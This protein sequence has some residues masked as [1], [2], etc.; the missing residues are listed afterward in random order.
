MKRCFLVFTDVDES[1]TSCAEFEFAC[2]A[3]SD[4]VELNGP[5]TKVS[6]S[7]KGGTPGSA[8]EG[9]DNTC[10]LAWDTGEGSDD[11]DGKRC[12]KFGYENGFSEGKYGDG[13]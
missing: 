3:D 2:A 9:V 12:C 4:A 5:G 8:N 10:V 1:D 11:D 7:C 13:T 6:C